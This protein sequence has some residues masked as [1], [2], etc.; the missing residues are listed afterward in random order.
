MCDSQG[1]G[2]NIVANEVEIKGKMFHLRVKNWVCTKVRRANIVTID[3]RCG[4]E[5]Y[6]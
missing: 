2:L 1:T 3:C 4:G 5:S 6:A